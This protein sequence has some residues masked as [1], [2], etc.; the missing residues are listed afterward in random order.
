VGGVFLSA[1]ISL[2]DG[3]NVRFI[4]IIFSPLR[5]GFSATFVLKN[6]IVGF[7]NGSLPFVK[8]V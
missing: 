4:L 5:T 1:L 3:V 8:M 6:M 2:I 7:G